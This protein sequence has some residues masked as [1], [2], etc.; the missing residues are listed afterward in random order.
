MGM[1]IA[2]V[3]AAV[4]AAGASGAMIVMWRQYRSRTTELAERE[5][6]LPQATRLEALARRIDEGETRLGEL[7]RELVDA[8]ATVGRKHDAEQW[9]STHEPQLRSFEAERQE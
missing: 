9:L 1:T 3:I 8:Q 4:I 7:Q 2:F 5:A 6:R